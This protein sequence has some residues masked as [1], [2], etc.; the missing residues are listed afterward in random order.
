MRYIKAKYIED[1]DASDP[2]EQVFT[3]RCELLG[4]TYSR[5]GPASGSN[6]DLPVRFRLYDGTSSSGTLLF[7][8]N[9]GRTGDDQ[10]ITPVFNIFPDGTSMPC[11][12]GI[13]FQYDNTTDSGS[14]VYA[15]PN[16]V[17]VLFS[18]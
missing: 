10:Q 18:A 14:A 6:P 2:G 11:S 7:E 17:T 8:V 5:R 1:Y 9:S 12:T 16:T 13:Y 15:Y 4:V 3:G